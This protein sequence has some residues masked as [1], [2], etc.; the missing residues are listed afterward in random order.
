M[1]HF[2]ILVCV[3][4][5]ALI[6]S[7]SDLFSQTLGES[8][9]TN[10]RS[11]F[12]NGGGGDAISL[13][14]SY[15][16]VRAYHF[17]NDDQGLDD[18][19]VPNWP[20]K[21]FNFNQADSYYS[22]LK[23]SVIQTAFGI[24]GEMRGITPF[25]SPIPGYILQEFF[26][27]KAIIPLDGPFTSAPFGLGA[28]LNVSVI[29]PSGSY[30]GDWLVAEAS[31]QDDPQFHLLKAHW[32]TL[33]ADRYGS[34]QLQFGQ[35][36]HE[37]L[38]TRAQ[39]ENGYRADY[40]VFNNGETRGTTNWFEGENEP[41]RFWLDNRAQSQGISDG[42][43]SDND[44]WRHSPEILASQTSM[45]YDGHGKSAVSS[46]PYGPVPGE[47]P[48]FVGIKNVDGNNNLA[49]A[50]LAG[51]RGQYIEDMV[52][53][54]IDNRK[55]GVYGFEDPTAN[56]LPFDAI[57]VH[58]Y[59]A[60]N[61]QEAEE[62]YETPL[63]GQW[64][65][66]FPGA[67]GE[68]PEDHSLR[69]RME[70]FITRLYTNI[71]SRPENVYSEME[72]KEIWLSE[73]GY[74]SNNEEVIPG[75]STG[76]VQIPELNSSL[77]PNFPCMTAACNLK[78][79]KE[80]VQ[81]QWLSRSYLELMAVRATIPLLGGKT[82]KHVDKFMQYE[83]RDLDDLPANGIGTTQFQTAGLLEVDGTPKVSHF[84][85]KTLLHHLGGFEM[86]ELTGAV[87]NSD[88]PNSF[89]GAIT[90][91]TSGQTNPVP[92][93]APVMYKYS[94]PS[95]QDIK[96]VAWSPT[97]NGYSYNIEL[98]VTSLEGYVAGETKIS[99]IRMTDLSERGFLEEYEQATGSN[100]FS[101]DVLDGT[102]LY[103]DE[104]P[105]IITLSP[106]NQFTDV[107]PI[108]AIGFTN[109]CC[110]NVEIAFTRNRRNLNGSFT[111]G[112]V[113]V[114]DVPVGSSFIDASLVTIVGTNV[115]SSP[116]AIS[117]LEE[118]TDYYIV[119]LPSNFRGFT[120][121]VTNGIPINATN[122]ANPNRRYVYTYT[123]EPCESEDE[124]VYEI[125]PDWITISDN[126]TYNSVNT[127]AAALSGG[128][129]TDGLK[130]DDGP[131][132][133]GD[134]W[135]DTSDGSE[136]QIVIDFPNPVT[137]RYVSL[138]TGGITANS[139]VTSNFQME[140]STCT[141]PDKWIPYLN[142]SP[143]QSDTRFNTSRTR[144]QVSHLRITKAGFNLA[145]LSI[146]ADDGVCAS[147]GP[148][149]LFPKP[150][151]DVDHISGDNAS[152][153]WI[154]STDFETALSPTGY[155]IELAT[156]IMDDGELIDPVVY[157]VDA[158]DGRDLTHKFEDLE[159]EATY[160]G[161]LAPQDQCFFAVSPLT[162]ELLVGFE[163]GSY[164]EADTSTFTFTTQELPEAASL[165][166]PGP[167]VSDLAISVF[168]NPS[169]GDFTIHSNYGIKGVS[170]YNILGEVIYRRRNPSNSEFISFDV[171]SINR[172]GLFYVEVE[173]TNGVSTKTIVIEQ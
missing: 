151:V 52:T 110:G 14:N 120:I 152:I 3:A 99:V 21:P 112:Y 41:D 61:S 77:D 30:F 82:T 6:T 90:I 103:I 95:G 89:G 133:G 167:D 81:A 71:E 31:S 122:P 54:F 39:S 86:K 66:T 118:G 60:S 36:E 48:F 5:I 108:R 138:L 79:N 129:G 75:V 20:V 156:E 35:T 130:C 53:W 92:S 158:T 111:I 113:K 125:S 143:R 140:Y 19:N 83:M 154:S 157:M 15:P 74:D 40:A 8:F 26:L 128:T 137:L 134:Q 37:R 56:V 17:W 171:T 45:V 63:E 165:R 87:T 65:P 106:V 153:S 107:A 38:Y 148:G 145:A 58:H 16:L 96:Y 123:P 173:T 12:T 62:E 25:A 164:S 115:T 144:A 172:K 149:T 119:M 109:R 131:G 27:Q 22:G 104:T 72:G 97:S 116:F 59:P 84:F 121:N 78:L 101:V 43:G 13:Q 160:F 29:P 124:C 142:L 51:N 73:F 169:N 166:I 93:E 64:N 146:C 49:L 57:S 33:L 76:G 70:Y 32:M 18:D 42:A 88:F 55:D 139:S 68:S 155:S 98:D 136:M 28:N 50:G 2:T 135:G 67:S 161:R 47:K 114:S 7:S 44:A 46:W 100:N 1:K 11:P 132:P 105:M 85:T 162:P 150:L 170:L 117:G 141:C 10:S 147:G 159:S 127:I 9:G 34:S 23:S 80:L 4:L 24:P 102:P 69:T 94:D 163:V 168:P 126:F 91:P